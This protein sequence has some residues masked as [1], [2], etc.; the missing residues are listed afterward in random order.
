MR[1]FLIAFLMLVQ[2]VAKAQVL[3]EVGRKFDAYHQNILQ[4]KIFVHTDKDLYLTGEILWLKVYN[5]DAANGRVSLHSKVVYVEILD[6]RNAPVVQAKI[7]MKDGT[8]SGSLYIPLTIVNGMYKLR[9]YT[10]WMKNFGPQVF[11][12]KELTL[13]NP[14]TSPEQQKEQATEQDLQFFPEG[15]DL[16]EGMPGVVAFKALGKNGLGID[17]KGVVVDQRN[18]TVARFES[19]KFGIGRFTFIPKANSSYKAIASTR[20]KDVIIKALPAAKQQG[21]T[22][23]LD[24]R[25]GDDIRVNIGTNLNA[26][27]TYLFVHDGKKIAAA[28]TANFT[29]GKATFQLSKDK[30]NEGV[31]HFTIFNEDGQAVAERLYFKRP[32]GQL[33][34]A[35]SA[36]A[37]Q[38]NS[39]KKVKVNVSVKNEKNEPQH[40]DLSVSVH[41]VDSLQGMKQ[42]NIVSYLWLS[43]ELKGNIELPAYYLSS[44]DQERD[45]ALDNLLLT[46]GWR[47]FAWNDL[48]DGQKPLFKFLPEL[49]GHL[50]TG[51]ITNA[52]KE[53]KKNANV[54]LT[55]PGTKFQFYSA[56]SDSTGQF[57]FNTNNFYGVHELVI[58]ANTLLDSTAVISVESPFIEQY[59]RFDPAS[60]TFDPALNTQLQDHSF[61]MQVQN[62]YS[63]DKFKQFYKPVIDTSKFYGNAFKTYKLSDYTHFTILEDVLREYVSEVFVTKRQKSFHLKILSNIGLLNEEPLVLFNG[64]PYFSIDK[65]MAITPDKIERLEVVPNRYLYGSSS[66]EGILSFSSF[67]NDLTDIDINPHAVVLDYEGMQLQREFYTPL[68]ETEQQVKSRIPDF[69]NVLYWMPTLAIDATGKGEVNFYTSDFA[70]T[71]VMVVQGLSD[72]GVPGHTYF[73]FEVKK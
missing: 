48:K 12:E 3:N 57:L 53:P 24:N 25:G 37:I 67:K 19:L 7:A 4:E 31:S 55:L 22:M 23:S 41:R 14:L 21:Y 60:F 11:F 61:N 13:I 18:D 33:Q 32:T 39:R 17:L 71:Y 63:G 28:E 35:T 5:T 8:G 16:V 43:S 65:A 50:L 72:R 40:A 20:N 38:F 64:V 9:A 27:K 26:T 42:D 62:A 52:N 29:N 36:E 6:Q 68:Y 49:N 59:N 47:R 51:K 44:N 2:V 66:F 56:L 30:L 70:G 45:L 54:Y 69:R 1:L 34:L 46:Q 73:Q 58:Q 10:N 15:G